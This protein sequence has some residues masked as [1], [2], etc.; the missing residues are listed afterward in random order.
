[1]IKFFFNYCNMLNLLENHYKSNI[2]HINLYINR[3]VP[4]RIWKL[5]FYVFLC[6]RKLK[7]PFVNLK[8]NNL[9]LQ[10][11]NEVNCASYRTLTRKVIRNCIR[12]VLVH[13]Y[14]VVCLKQILKR[15][16]QVTP[17]TE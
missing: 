6:I 17:R 3:I 4:R 9:K 7:S 2:D 13:V 16:K 8:Y 1:M 10:Q 15:F 14:E 12:L 5:I 11:Q